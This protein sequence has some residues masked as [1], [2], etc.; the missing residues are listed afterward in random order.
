LFDVI[1]SG[2][3]FTECDAALIIKQM[4]L[5]MNY[6]HQNHIV[7]RD[8]KPD[9]VL[10]ESINEEDYST[11]KIID[12]GTSHRFKENEEIEGVIGTPY[13][14]APEVFQGTYS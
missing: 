10:L 13:Y 6:C 9:N 7:H 12:F 1:L 8:L 14:I 3:K 2:N 11:L 4:L 5:C